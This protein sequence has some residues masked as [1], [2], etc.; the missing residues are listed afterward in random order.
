MPVQ[1][2][3]Q[4]VVNR[5]EWAAAKV[6]SRAPH[7]SKVDTLA[8]QASGDLDHLCVERIDMLRSVTR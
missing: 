1:Q 2:I 8:F 7:H 6:E 5:V 4:G 3:V